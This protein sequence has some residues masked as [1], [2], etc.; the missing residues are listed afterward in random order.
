MDYVALGDEVG[1][2]PLHHEVEVVGIGHSSGCGFGAHGRGWDCGGQLETT[3]DFLGLA[4]D[5]VDQR[6]NLNSGSLA[7]ELCRGP[8]PASTQANQLAYQ[9]ENCLVG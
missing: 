7:I 1:I 5:R 4:T 3:V 2:E 6:T 9:T 8:K